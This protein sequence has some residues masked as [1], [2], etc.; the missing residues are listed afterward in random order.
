MK[1]S[2]SIL[3][4]AIVTIGGGMLLKVFRSSQAVSCS[5]RT[6]IVLILNMSLICYILNLIF[7]YDVILY[8][9]MFI[10]I[11]VFRDTLRQCLGLER[12]LQ[13]WLANLT[14]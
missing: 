13:R 5:A 11:F 9:K 2:A 14:R 10:L 12:C 4:I 3:F 1:I 6:Q 8:M 7:N